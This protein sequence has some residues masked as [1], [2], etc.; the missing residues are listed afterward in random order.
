MTIPKFRVYDKVE[1]MMITTSDYED[2]SDLFCILKNDADTGYISELMQS[3]C[4][5]DKNGKEVFEN[6]VIRD[7]DGFE[8]IVQYDESYGMYGIA[9]L[10]TLSNG[11]D[12]TF[13]ELKDNYRNEF[14]VIGNI[15][16]NPEFL[17][18]VE[19]H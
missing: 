4:L 6:D 2:L 10:P 13:E 3:T 12:M 19:W 7:S 17:E 11:I 1:C 15:Y 14:E 8:G 5:I 18:G 16:E 9:Y